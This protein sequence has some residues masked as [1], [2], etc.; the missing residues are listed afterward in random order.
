MLQVTLTNIV[1]PRAVNFI[2]IPVL[3]RNIWIYGQALV[4]SPTIGLRS[5]MK[6]TVRE[7]HQDWI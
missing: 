7:G 4:L 2:H 5:K 6:N 3:E 1:F